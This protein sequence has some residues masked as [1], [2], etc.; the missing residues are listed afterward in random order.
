M[1]RHRTLARALVIAGALVLVTGCSDAG[2]TT[3]ATGLDLSST[4][5]EVA[6]ERDDD[7]TTTGA[8]ATTASTTTTST[9]TTST[10]E[11]SVETVDVACAAFGDTMLRP[12]GSE[13]PERDDDAFLAALE[14]LVAAGPEPTPGAA[15]AVLALD[16]ASAAAEAGTLSPEE[17]LAALRASHEGLVALQD[18][19]L[20][21]CPVEG[22]VWSCPVLTGLR[23]FVP[24]GEPIADE[25]GE[26]PPPTTT[27]PPMASPEEVYAQAESDGEPVEISRTDDEVVV[28]WL[29]DA[30]HAV[31][32]LTVV[33][34]DGWRSDG[35]MACDDDA[36]PWDGM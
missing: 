35:T 16:D 29:D 14:A 25:D 18:W 2:G 34:A 10:T 15:A 24:V 32:V 12:I 20:G 9:T 1:A 17:A 30:G 8:T 26:L 23:T 4:T 11:P 27:A 22:V 5:T 21:A 33:D 19:A 3:T 28:A 31:E 7:T 36:M 13:P 6:E